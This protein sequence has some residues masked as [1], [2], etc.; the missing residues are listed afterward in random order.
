M[1]GNR[2]VLSQTGA[3]TAAVIKS[4]S[5][6]RRDSRWRPDAFAVIV[7]IDTYSDPRIPN[8]QFARKDAEAVYQV[9]T[10]PNVGRFNPDNV[11]VL[12]DENATE[13][14]IRSALGTK[15]PRRTS[16]TSTVCIYYAGHGAPVIDN[17]ARRNS[18]DSIEKV[19][20]PHDPRAGGLR[21]A[22]ISMDLVQEF[23]PWV[24]AKQVIFFLH[25]CFHR[26]PGRRSLQPR[27]FPPPPIFSDE[28]LDR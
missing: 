4:L 23:F 12:V 19:L 13:R 3:L 27:L 10:D 20:V 14:K 2:D 28:H 21:S 9:L 16:E 18:A 15:L 11:I 22:A 6:T 25:P 26:P 5:P 17:D 1:A 8:L 7:G 24:G